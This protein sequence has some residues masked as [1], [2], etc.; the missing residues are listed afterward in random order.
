MKMAA[1]IAQSTAQAG[2]CCF[3]EHAGAVLQAAILTAALLLL[4]PNVQ[5][6]A[7]EHVQTQSTTH[8]R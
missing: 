7:A 8:A 3:A 4:P 1:T 6:L 2:L 5:A